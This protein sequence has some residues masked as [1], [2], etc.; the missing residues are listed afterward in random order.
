LVSGQDANLVK[1]VTSNRLLDTIRANVPDS[2]VREGDSV[3]HS[4]LRATKEVE[5]AHGVC[6]RLTINNH[7]QSGIMIPVSFS[8]LL[9][10]VRLPMKPNC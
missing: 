8:D 10:L 2:I 3:S 7:F 6:S 4:L 1:V 5:D 9:F